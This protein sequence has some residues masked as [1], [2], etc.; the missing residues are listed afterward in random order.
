[1][2]LDKWVNYNWLDLSRNYNSINTTD[3]FQI[4]CEYVYVGIINKC[5]LPEEYTNGII[6]QCCSI[7]MLLYISP[8]YVLL[9]W[10]EPQLPLVI[11]Q[12]L[13]LSNFTFIEASSSWIIIIIQYYNLLIYFQSV[14]LVGGGDK[15]ASPYVAFRQPLLVA[16]KNL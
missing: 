6:K 10:I 3:N 15:F 11:K 12:R 14:Y 8:L 7:Q 13:A 4:F 2:S 1:M 9:E 5:W 16:F